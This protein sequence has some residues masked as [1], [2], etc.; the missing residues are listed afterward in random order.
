MSLLPERISA[1]I[2]GLFAPISKPSVAGIQSNRA[3]GGR[4]SA[5]GKRLVSAILRVMDNHEPHF[6]NYH[7]VLNRCGPVV[8]ASRYCSSFVS[9]FVQRR[10]W[11]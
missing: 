2:L 10:A 5:P 4:D 7:R 8:H 6:Q 9:V 3:T 11:D 1:L